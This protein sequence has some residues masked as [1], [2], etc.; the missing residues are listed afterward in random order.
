[1]HTSVSSGVL[2][3]IRP[4]HTVIENIKSYVRSLTQTD[5][6]PNKTHNDLKVFTDKFLPDKTTQKKYL[7]TNGRMYY[8]NGNVIH[9]VAYDNTP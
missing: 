9:L 1:M 4:K 5:G 7:S 8:Y 6:F 2:L 3:L